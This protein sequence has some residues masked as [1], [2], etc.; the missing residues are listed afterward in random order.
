MVVSRSPK[1]FMGVRISLPLLSQVKSGASRAFS[2]PRDGIVPHIAVIGK[3][4]RTS[5]GV[6]PSGPKSGVNSHSVQKLSPLFGSC[7]GRRPVPRRGLRPQTPV[8]RA[9]PGPG[10]RSAPVRANPTS[11]GRRVPSP[12][13]GKESFASFPLQEVDPCRL[14]KRCPGATRP[15]YCRLPPLPLLLY[16]RFS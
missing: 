2:F 1:P 15:A 8:S 14:G 12:V 16:F 5:S 11:P 4:I 3:K 6:I 13:A 9:L 10:L 7:P